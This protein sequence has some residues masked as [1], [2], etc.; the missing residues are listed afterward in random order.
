MRNF[1][2]TKIDAN[3]KEDLMR[4]HIPATANNDW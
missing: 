2:N 1:N 4:V 3:Y